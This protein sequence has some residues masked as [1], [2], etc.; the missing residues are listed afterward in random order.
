MWSIT[1]KSNHL[2]RQKEMSLVNTIPISK[3]NYESITS[4]VDNTHLC[5]KKLKQEILLQMLEM[6]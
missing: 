4:R 5:L 2:F 6:I 3:A 1:A